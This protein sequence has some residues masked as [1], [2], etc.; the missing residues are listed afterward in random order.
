MK[1]HIQPPFPPVEIFDI[2]RPTQRLPLLAEAS[3]KEWKAV[4]QH[5]YRGRKN[6]A[7]LEVSGGYDFDDE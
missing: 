6:K 2:D 1:A 5:W 3:G 7:F 4:R